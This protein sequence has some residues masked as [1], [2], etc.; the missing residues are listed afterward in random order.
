[1]HADLS[2]SSA[3]RA[4]TSWLSPVQWR[5]AGP[6]QRVAA[7]RFHHRRG[8]GARRLRPPLCASRCDLPHAIEN[9]V[10]GAYFNSGQSCCGLQRIYVH[11]SVYDRFT[12]GC[13]EL[14]QQ[15]PAR[16]SAGRETTLGRWCAPRRQTG[17]AHRCARAIEAG[18]RPVIE[19]ARLPPQQ[20]R[21]ALS[22]TAVAPGRPGRLLGH[23]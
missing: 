7:E 6:L 3:I 8:A 1:V 14:I 15:L 22:G 16:R 17:Y 4:S 21:Y 9:I 13:I 19:R 20:S 5:G 18:A 12:R 10:D 2:E 11:E 23:A